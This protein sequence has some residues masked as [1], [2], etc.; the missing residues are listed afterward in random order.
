MD[1][2]YWS[3]E[4]RAHHVNR[5]AIRAIC[6][7]L[8]NVFG[9]SKTLADEMMALEA[10]AIELGEAIDLAASRLW[11]LQTE[12]AER[13]ISERLLQL[14]LLT[15]TYDDILRNSSSA[16]A[17][18]AHAN[19]TRGL[20]EIGHLE[21]RDFDLREACNKIVHALIIRPLY[22]DVDPYVVEG[23]GEVQRFWYLTGEIE[24]SGR[25]RNADWEAVLHVQ[26][27]VETVLDRIEFGDP[28]APGDQVE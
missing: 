12:F 3:S 16:Q 17:Y 19:A 6:F 9:G 13:A 10:E 1:N 2:P 8:L 26:P 11:A 22:E 18:G 20:D 24:L 4:N 5:D 15:R 14:A 25:W 7:D 21:G 23:Q 27:F 28:P